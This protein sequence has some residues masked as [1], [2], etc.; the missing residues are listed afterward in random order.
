MNSRFQPVKLLPHPS[1]KTGPVRSISASGWLDRHEKLTVDYELLGDLA[2]ISLPA[3]AIAPAR[4][5]G[6][7][8]HSCFE[9]FAQPDAGPGYVEFNFS[10]SGDWASYAFGSY[11][12]RHPVEGPALTTMEVHHRSESRFTLRACTALRAASRSAASTWSWQLGIA[13]VIENMNGTRSY[14]ALQHPRREPDF[15]DA[16]AFAVELARTPWA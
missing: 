2:A 7:W 3:A 15:H 11:R 6:L 1:C 8:Q 10:P 14:W 16:A 12:G 13:A 5:D 9:L 4:L